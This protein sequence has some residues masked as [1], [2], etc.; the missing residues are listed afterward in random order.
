MKV[1]CLSVSSHHYTAENDFSL[2]EYATP[3]HAPCIMLGRGLDSEMTSGSNLSKIC[4]QSG[5]LSSQNADQMRIW[6]INIFTSYNK[7]QLV[8]Y[9]IVF[10]D[11]EDTIPPT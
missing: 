9:V 2:Y 5:F 6:N 4:P 1:Q 11:S 3:I 10:P 8:A 7:W